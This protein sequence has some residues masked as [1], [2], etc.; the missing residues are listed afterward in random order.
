MT[1]LFNAMSPMHHR[2]PGLAGAAF[3]HPRVICGVI[4]DGLHVHPEVV[5]LAFRMLGPDRIY[6]VTD[7]TAATGMGPGVYSLATRTIYQDANM[8]R[9]GSGAMAGSLIT[10]VEA[11]QN[12]LA[13][14]GCTIAEAS[15]MASTTPAR[16]CGEGR[17]KGRLVAGYDADV[18]VLAPDLSIRAVWKGG[19]KVY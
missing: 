8:A 1:H 7:S 12:I 6:L 11:F 19:G 5:G 13:F 4:A 14:T 9:L 16:L 17:C 18:T 3:A 2:H 10:M 15:R